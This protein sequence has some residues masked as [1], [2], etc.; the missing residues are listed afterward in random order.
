MGSGT[1]GLYEGTFGSAG[2]SER[3][4]ADFGTGVDRLFKGL[5]IRPDERTATVWLHMTATQPNYPGTYLPRSFTMRTP[6]GDF[7]THGHGTKHMYSAVRKALGS[8]SFKGANHGMLTQFLLYDYRK[9]LIAASKSGIRLDGVGR[10]YGHW[11][12][13]FSKRAKNKHPVVMH[14][15]FL[16]FI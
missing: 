12:L 16:G 15:K 9:S 13:G 8:T 14:A 3:A 4:G 5:G 10:T 1:S 6:N 7:W 2:V 11:E